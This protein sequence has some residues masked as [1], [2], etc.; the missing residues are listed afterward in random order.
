MGNSLDAARSASDSAGLAARIEAALENRI[1]TDRYAVWF[2]R[3]MTVRV[4]SAPVDRATVVA[5]RGRRSKAGDV[6]TPRPRGA[7]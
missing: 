5:P 7:T 2:G 6:V 1:G 3:S 4:E